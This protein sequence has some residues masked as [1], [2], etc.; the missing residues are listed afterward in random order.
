[1]IRAKLITMKPYSVA[2]VDDHTMIR[3]GLV[4]LINTFHDYQVQFHAGNFDEMIENLDVTEI[5]DVILLDI[6][7]PGKNGYEVALWLR[8]NRPEIKVCAL[9]MFDNELSIIRMLKNGVRGYVLKASPPNELKLALDS[10][11]HKGYHYSELL[12]GHLLHSVQHQSTKNGKDIELSEREIT[13]LKYACSEL[14]YKEIASK[15][16]LSARTIDGYRDKLCEKLN[17]SSRIGLVLY[18]IKNRIINIEDTSPE[19][20]K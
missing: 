1:M 11:I 4:E 3:I 10:I 9:S 19:K 18:A 7:L 20:M 5:P 12:S 8:N 6:N 14:T 16:F 2:L 13:F 15:M 17:V